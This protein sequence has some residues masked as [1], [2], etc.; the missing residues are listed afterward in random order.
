VKR[1]FTR[2]EARSG[3]LA[4]KIVAEI[5]RLAR[6]DGINRLALETG[7]VPGFAAA[8][9]VYERAGFTRCGAFLDYPVET[10]HNIYYEKLLA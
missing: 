1:M 5:E 7:S 2:P 8:W 9:S 3:G 10:E 6:Q 4:G